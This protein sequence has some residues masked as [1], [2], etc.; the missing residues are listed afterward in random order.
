MKYE[1]VNF[2]LNKVLNIKLVTVNNDVL[3]DSELVY[4]YF[5]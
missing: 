1:T 2:A 3:A 5:S 4:I